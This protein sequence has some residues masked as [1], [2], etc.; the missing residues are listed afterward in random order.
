MEAIATKFVPWDVNPLE[1]L[2]D[3]IV[4]K[5]RKLINSGRSLNRAQKS[6]ITTKVNNNSYFNNA[7]PCQGWMFRFGDVL[8]KY[9]V[10]QYGECHEYYAV[11][12][13]SLREY[14]GNREIE[15]ILEI[16]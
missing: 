8:K 13:T 2:K 9:V 16:K 12:K 3:T 6:W 5:M 4:Y 1:D 15:Y 7:I 14:L 11:D 10:K